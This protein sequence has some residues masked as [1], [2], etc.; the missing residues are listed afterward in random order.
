MKI[1]WRLLLKI[2]IN[3]MLPVAYLNSKIFSHPPPL[4]ENPFK[5][6]CIPIRMPQPPPLKTLSEVLTVSRGEYELIIILSYF[7][8]I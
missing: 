3:Y 2:E 8:F 4:K 1:R 6:C 7:F 5:P